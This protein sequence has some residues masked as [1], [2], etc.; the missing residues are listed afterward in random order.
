M[1]IED[2][3]SNIFYQL[4]KNINIRIQSIIANKKLIKTKV[5]TKKVRRLVIVQTIDVS[6]TL[7]RYSYKK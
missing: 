2:S 6:T 5:K 4:K 7:I 3:L 1:Y